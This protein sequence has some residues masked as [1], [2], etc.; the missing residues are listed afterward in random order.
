MC[1]NQGTNCGNRWSDEKAFE[2]QT[3]RTAFGTTEGTAKTSPF[4][5]DGSTFKSAN[6]GCDHLA[7]QPQRPGSANVVEDG[8]RTHL[9]SDFLN[10]SNGFLGRRTMDCIALLDSY[11]N[12]RNNTIGS[13]GRRGEPLF[14]VYTNSWHNESQTNGFST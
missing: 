14:I 3:A 10:C 13:S 11:I 7:S 9:E 12:N 1:S 2:S 4:Q 8:A 6:G 5:F